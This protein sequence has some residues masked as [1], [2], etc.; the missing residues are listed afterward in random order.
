MQH[1]KWTLILHR[2]SG[3]LSGL[4]C[5]WP[6]GLSCYFRQLQCVVLP[7]K[8]ILTV[9]LQFQSCWVL[10]HV[11]VCL[12]DVGEWGVEDVRV[13]SDQLS[14]QVSTDSR[15]GR[16]VHACQGTHQQC[17]GNEA[18]SLLQGLFESRKFL[19]SFTPS[20][21]ISASDMMFCLC[22]IT[23]TWCFILCSCLLLLIHVC[24]WWNRD[25][26]SQFSCT[27]GLC[28]RCWRQSLC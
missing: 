26:C 15:L 17:H 18:V 11:P 3:F 14:E 25:R 28:H 21:N 24:V 27:Y 20:V 1:C 6:V 13:G 4:T 10:R 16:P 23:Q 8:L 12:G 19:L 7:R 22:S 2:R 9:R 5:K